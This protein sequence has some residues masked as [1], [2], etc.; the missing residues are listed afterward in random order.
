M[1]IETL[2]SPSTDIYTRIQQSSMSPEN[3]EFALNGY[4]HDA[5][6]EEEAL[7]EDFLNA[8]RPLYET[9]F[10]EGG[11]SIMV[12]HFGQTFLGANNIQ[13]GHTLGVT[14]YILHGPNEVSI[15]Q[16]IAIGA[17]GEIA[18][19]VLGKHDHRGAGHD[20]FVGRVM[21][22]QYHRYISGFGNIYSEMRS[23]TRSVL[24]NSKARLDNFAWKLFKNRVVT[25]F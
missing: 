6:N 7:D 18:E 14:K 13:E 17:G 25:S 22:D 24:F 19:E 15:P 23:R 20:R 16:S 2:S 21:A 4:R 10:H 1:A 9:S 12:A 5:F 8:S 11:H 3:K